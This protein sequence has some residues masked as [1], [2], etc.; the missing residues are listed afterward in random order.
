MAFNYKGNKGKNS[1]SDATKRHFEARIK[2]RKP[3]KNS[4]SDGER[5]MSFEIGIKFLDAMKL[6]VI[7]QEFNFLCQKEKSLRL[8]LK[9]RSQSQN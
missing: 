7:R 8:E 4:I 5:E 3:G 1:I 6:K 9:F 2:F